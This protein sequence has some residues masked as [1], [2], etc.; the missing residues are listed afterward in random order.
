MRGFIWVLSSVRIRPRNRSSSVRGAS[1]TVTRTWTADRSSVYGLPCAVPAR[2][3]TGTEAA[4]AH[5][6]HRQAPMPAR[7][8]KKHP[9]R[10]DLAHCAW[11]VHS[12]CPV[13]CGWSVHQ[14]LSVRG[15]WPAPASR[16]LTSTC[17]F[18]RYAAYRNGSARSAPPPV[19]SSAS[20]V[21]NKEHAQAG[22]LR[23]KF[24]KEERSQQPKSCPK[25]LI[26]FVFHMVFP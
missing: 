20:C 18:F 1:T 14:R 19:T 17:S 26:V 15:T 2:Q 5:S 4:G 8:A 6:G 16:S 11:P 3:T 24:I 13:R 22:S 25:R 21:P 12:H 9:V 23:A 10:K 7:A